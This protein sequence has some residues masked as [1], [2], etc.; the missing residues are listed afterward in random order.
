MRKFMMV[1][2]FFVGL[3]LFVT[4]AKADTLHRDVIAIQAVPAKTHEMMSVEFGAF[5]DTDSEEEIFTA[6]SGFAL[7]G[8]SL[9]VSVAHDGKNKDM[10]MMD[11]PSYSVA[12]GTSAKLGSYADLRVGIAPKLFDVDDRGLGT[13]GATIRFGF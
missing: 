3:A 11:Q 13:V 9:G 1:A 2:A 6:G 4:P 8:F 12:V 10:M 7:W 5:Y